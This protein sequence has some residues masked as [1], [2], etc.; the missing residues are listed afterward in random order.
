MPSRPKQPYFLEDAVEN[1]LAANCGSCHGPDAPVAGSGGIR[2]ISDLDELVEAGLIVPL[3]SASSPVVRV[4]VQGSMPPPSSGLPQ[5]TEADL[6]T[7]TSY[8]DNPRY[9][10]IS[11]PP[12]VDAGTA[13]PALDAGADG[14]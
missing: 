11:A 1:I 6:D 3:N 13:P 10:P 7:I 4:S 9:W 12:A 8:I 2:F 5:M 14:G